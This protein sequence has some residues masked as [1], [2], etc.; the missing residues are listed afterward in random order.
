M[1]IQA[2][3]KQE[4]ENTKKII[5]TVPT[6]KVS[7]K[8]VGTFLLPKWSELYAAISGLAQAQ[9]GCISPG[10]SPELSEESWWAKV[11]ALAQGLLQR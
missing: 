10:A 3:T 7:P 11:V 5:Q 1:E 8:M 6:M 9:G 2:A 4:P